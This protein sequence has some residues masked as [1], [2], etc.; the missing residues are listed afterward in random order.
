M[1]DIEKAPT[2]SS[3][4]VSFTTLGIGNAM[5][6]FMLGVVCRKFGIL[7]NMSILAVGSQCDVLSSFTMASSVST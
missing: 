1:V 6:R 5:R 3:F 2:T 4:R 7:F